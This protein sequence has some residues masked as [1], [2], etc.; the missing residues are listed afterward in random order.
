MEQYR[1]VDSREGN[2]VK[3]S[4]VIFCLTLAACGGNSFTGS[5]GGVSFT[6]RDAVFDTIA[7]DDGNGRTGTALYLVMADGTGLCDYL[8][9]ATAPQS[10]TLFETELVSLDASSTLQTPQ[11]GKYPVSQFL[12]AEPGNSA[13]ALFAKYDSHCQDT[14]A[15]GAGT[16]MS[17]TFSLDSVKA[18]S[19]GTLSG[20]FDVTF[21]G[22]DAGKGDLHATF[23]KLPT[24]GGT[25]C[26]R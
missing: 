6:P 26:P 5:V 24:T 18:A 23:C 9:A 11:P 17:G 25:V 12:T 19:G 22:T 2:A 1:R 3:I 21:S 16:A 13:E 7:I 4:L 8:Q 15:T 10:V 20:S 14:L